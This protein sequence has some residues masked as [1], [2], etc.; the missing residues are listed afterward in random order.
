[1]PSGLAGSRRVPRQSSIVGNP[2]LDVNR[3]IGCFGHCGC[4]FVRRGA[5]RCARVVSD[6]G[7]GCEDLDAVAL[8]NSYSRRTP[9]SV[10]GA[11]VA[12]VSGGCSSV[13]R[14]P[15]CDSGC[16]GFE[17]HQPPHLL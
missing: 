1:M 11:R 9:V 8:Y 14:V 2:V 10:T 3:R 13:G 7:T 5:C 15:D 4:V 16:R 17:S 6:D 12:I